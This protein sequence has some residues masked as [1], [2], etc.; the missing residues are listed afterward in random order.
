MPAN[1]IVKDFPLKPDETMPAELAFDRVRDLADADK[2]TFKMGSSTL[3]ILSVAPSNTT[4]SIAFKSTDPFDVLGGSP[5]QINIFLEDVK[6]IHVNEM[7]VKGKVPVY[8][9]SV[10]AGGTKRPLTFQCASAD[11][12]EHLVSA[13]EYFIRSSRVGHDIPLASLPYVNQGLRLNGGCEVTTL[14]ANSPAGKTNLN[15][16]DTLWSIGKD[17][18]Y[19]S[20][21]A[22]LEAGLNALT[23]GKYGLII[24]T[25]EIRQK[26]NIDSRNGG[27]YNP[28]R[29]EVDLQ[30]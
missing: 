16:G 19:Q 26:S 30:I 11:D 20:K 8:Q 29:I 1:C 6:F 21:N 14:W 24:L 10:V 28:K 17:G 25:P 2:Y 5:N 13:L 18:A 9:I 27:N 4:L 7:D 12:V 22:D 3:K 15:V 23:P